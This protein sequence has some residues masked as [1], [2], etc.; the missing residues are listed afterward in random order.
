ML[1]RQFDCDESSVMGLVSLSQHSIIGYQA[2]NSIIGKLFK[3]VNGGSNIR[4]YSAFVARCTE[5][6]RR[7][8]N[9]EGEQYRG[10]GGW[11][12]F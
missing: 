1:N 8:L 6:A 11:E 10:Q 4:N 3:S 7:D 12:K 9:P 2:A 5:T